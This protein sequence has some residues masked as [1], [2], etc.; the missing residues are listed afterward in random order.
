MAGRN[1]DFNICPRPEWSFGEVVQHAHAVYMGFGVESI[2]RRNVL[3]RVWAAMV[4]SERAVAELGHFVIQHDGEVAAAKEVGCKVSTLR[5]LR[6]QFELVDRAPLSP[7]SLALTVGEQLRGRN[8][9]YEVDARLG[10]G[11]MGVVYRVHRLAGDESFA[12][13]L[14]SSERFA[15]TNVVKDRFVR[16][17][18]LAS[19]FASERVVKSIECL[20]HRGTLVSVMELLSGSNLYEALQG[21]R[22]NTSPRQRLAWLTQVAEGMAYLHE[23][24][25]VHRDLSPRNCLLRTDGSVAVGDFGVARRMDDFTM[26]TTHE[27]MGSLIYISPQQRDNPHAAKFTDDVYAFGQVG[28][29]ILTGRSPHGGIERIADLGYPT[30]LER[31]IKKM[32]DPDAARRHSDCADAL[33]EFVTLGIAPGAL[34]SHLPGGTA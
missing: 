21:D 27:R 28:Y 30:A 2:G 20:H 29:H 7:V 3:L 34:P 11:G 18:A 17:S 10:S 25:I 33:R 26:T 14:L 5:R 16:E 22:V 13:K 24:Q 4:G 23:Q 1:E 32:R 6:K 9:P 8:G 31:W 15:I 19:D 12:A